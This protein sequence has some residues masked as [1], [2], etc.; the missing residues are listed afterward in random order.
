MINS[1][2]IQNNTD[3]HKTIRL[4]SSFQNILN[5]KSIIFVQYQ[6][7]TIPHLNQEF[8]KPITML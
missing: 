5:I 1:S 6:M 8:Q 2:L 3:L 7:K 4:G